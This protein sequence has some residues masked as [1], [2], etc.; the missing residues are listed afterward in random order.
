[1]VNNKKILP[2]GSFVLS[3][4]PTDPGFVRTLS[5]EAWLWRVL[6]ESNPMFDALDGDARRQAADPLLRVFD[7]LAGLVPSG[8]FAY[9]QIMRRAY[10]EFKLMAVSTPVPWVP[11]RKLDAGFR[12]MLMLDHPELTVMDKVSVFGVK[13]RSGGRKGGKRNWFLG[14]F[15]D[16]SYTARYGV[17]SDMSFD[18]DRNVIGRLLESCGCRVPSAGQM[19]RVKAWW[20]TSRLPD[21]TPLMVEPG[22]VHTF[23]SWQAAEAAQLYH[24]RGVR[25]STWMESGDRMRGAYAMSLAALGPLPFDGVDEL[26]DPDAIWASRLLASTRAGGVGAMCVCLSGAVEPGSVTAAQMRRDEEKVVASIDRRRK[27]DSP[28][29]HSRVR[30]AG[31]LEGWASAYEA[32]GS[33]TPPTIVDGSCLVAVPRILDERVNDLEYP[34]TVKFNPLRQEAALQAMQLGSNVSYA[35]SPVSWPSP[36]VAFAGFCGVSRAGEGSGALLGVTE[37]DRQPVFVSPDAATATDSEPIMVVLGGTGSGKTW[38][39]DHLCAQWSNMVNPTTGRGVV[40]GLIFDPKQKSDFSRFVEAMGGTVVRLDDA[41]FAD[42][43]LDPVRCMSGSKDFR[44]EM[45]GTAVDLLASVL[46]PKG[47]DAVM[48]ADLIAILNY[49]LARG[50]DCSG[51]AVEVAFRDH[52]RGVDRGSHGGLVPDS[53]GVIRDRLLRLASSDMFRIL[54]GLKS[55]GFTLKASEGLT[56][57]MAGDLNLIP[58]DSPSVTNMVRRWVVRMSALGAAAAMMGRGGYV[59][60]D[61]AW[62]LL[63]DRMGAAVAQRFGRLGRLQKYL[64]IFAS[65]R[66]QEFVDAHL[67]SYVSRGILLSLSGKGD[68]SRDMESEATSALRLFG[69][70][71]KGR[72]HD[73]MVARAV[74]EDPGESGGVG[75][76]NWD[77]L[78]ALRKADGGVLRGAVCYYVGLSGRAVPVEVTIPSRLFR[79]L[80]SGKKKD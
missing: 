58:D 40:P 47:E 20:R 73:R 51:G 34:G 66:V 39:V 79:L 3:Q 72:L 23:P 32:A 5:G 71:T 25:C 6:P 41:R 10:R 24:E 59:F 1:M 78:R 30:M 13:L 53:V 57:V 9:R 15:E 4:D 68:G 48:Q 28:V 22:H 46:D 37:A 19:D 77:G 70:P 33:G 42:G 27:D 64:P 62:I 29:D 67:E 63:G 12:R 35:P 69:L 45:V 80:P 11:P 26:T 74:L 65:Q 55:G 7:A 36:L 38:T 2:A 56:L 52:E 18:A 76:P 61:E 17:E 49:G 31:D 16:M 60:V 14:Q 75:A 8:G 50:A 21:V 44:D 54:Y 43:A